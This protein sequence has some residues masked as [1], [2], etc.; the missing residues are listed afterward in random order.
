MILM[1]GTKMCRVAKKY[2]KEG[3]RMPCTY[4]KCYLDVIQKCDMLYQ[5]D[6]PDKGCDSQKIGAISICHPQRT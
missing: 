4:L 3:E 6:L 2:A 1:E 5:V